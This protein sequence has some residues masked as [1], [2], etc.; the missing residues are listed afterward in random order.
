MPLP[1]A[2]R[3]SSSVPTNL[4]HCLDFLGTSVFLLRIP[5]GCFKSENLSANVFMRQRDAEGIP[6]LS[7][8]FLL[9]D[10]ENGFYKSN[11]VGIVE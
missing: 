8:A 11:F 6:D 9:M 7:C 2:E 10:D 1:E 5:I 3:N 4:K